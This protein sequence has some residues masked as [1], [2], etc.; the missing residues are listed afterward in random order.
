MMLAS[1]LTGEGIRR[2]RLRGSRRTVRRWWWTANAARKAMAS[3]GVERGHVIKCDMGDDCPER[4]HIL[5][6]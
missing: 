6:N 1:K 3:A 2:L 4:L 5:S